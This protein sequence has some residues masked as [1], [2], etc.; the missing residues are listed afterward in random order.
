MSA[1]FSFLC[2]LI[3]RGE[4]FS[5]ELKAAMKAGDKRRVETIRTIMAALKEGN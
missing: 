2:N 4:K 3:G 5:T 1:P